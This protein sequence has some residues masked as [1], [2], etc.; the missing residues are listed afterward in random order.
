M[1]A[2]QEALI[3][4]F[5]FVFGYRVSLC[6]LGWPGTQCV[7]QSGPE[8]IQPALPPECGI[9]SVNTTL[10]AH[11]SFLR[12][13]LVVPDCKGHSAQGFSSPPS[14]VP[15]SFCPTN[16][17]ITLS[18]NGPVHLLHSPGDAEEKLTPSPG[19]QH[20]SLFNE[21]LL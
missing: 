16:T 18:S 13:N 7:N 11:I 2:P 10:G 12:T 14:L 17:Y 8:L 21:G 19:T 20:V 5:V 1:S 6:S 15:G 4:F 9:L 3:N